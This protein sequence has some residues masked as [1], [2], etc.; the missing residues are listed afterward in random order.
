MTFEQRSKQAMRKGARW[1][2]HLAVSVVSLRQ[3]GEWVEALG[4]TSIA[5]EQ[6][7]A[8][9]T[10]ASLPSPPLVVR[11]SS[12]VRSPADVGESSSLRFFCW[13]VS[14]RAM[15]LAWRQMGDSCMPS[16]P[17]LEP[18]LHRLGPR[19]L[20]HSARWIGV[21]L[22]VAPSRKRLSRCSLSRLSGVRALPSTAVQKSLRRSEVLAALGLACCLSWGAWKV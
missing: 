22:P 2:V 1:A 10:D 12:S 21:K 6:S 20:E 17:G 11:L 4:L 15:G 7:G 3:S 16:P 9:S 19:G 8:V 18:W 13:G 5:S 14:E